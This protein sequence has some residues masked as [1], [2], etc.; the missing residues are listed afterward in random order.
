MIFTGSLSSVWFL[1]RTS[2]AAEWLKTGTK[3]MILL[4]QSKRKKK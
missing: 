3:N 2:D 4:I 1:L